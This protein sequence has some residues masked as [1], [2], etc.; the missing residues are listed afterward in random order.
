MPPSMRF[1][2]A[3]NVLAKMSVKVAQFNFSQCQSSISFSMARAFIVFVNRKKRVLPLN[4]CLITP[5]LSSKAKCLR[6]VSQ[7]VPSLCA[8]SEVFNCPILYSSFKI[9]ILVL[10][11]KT[12]SISITNSPFQIKKGIRLPEALLPLRKRVRIPR[13]LLRTDRHFSGESK[14]R[15]LQNSI[16]GKRIKDELGSDL[17]EKWRVQ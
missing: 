13:E 9:F 8:K 4:R 12:S 7:F 6:V 15:N 2:H 16:S 10:E 14:A 1:P 5:S 17:P 11:Q 3:S